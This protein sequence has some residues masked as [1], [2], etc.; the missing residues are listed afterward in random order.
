MPT[1][2]QFPVKQVNGLIEFAGVPGMTNI[3]TQNLAD[4]FNSGRFVSP[5]VSNQE[6]SVALM[7]PSKN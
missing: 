5:Y 7:L 2:F 4:N 1:F 3:I 6:D